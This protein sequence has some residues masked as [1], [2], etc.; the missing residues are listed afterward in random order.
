MI[1]QRTWLIWRALHTPP[2]KLGK[3]LQAMRYTDD[4][5]APRFEVQRRH[6]AGVGLAIGIGLLLIGW[7]GSVDWLA[8]A[9]SGGL[10]VLIGVILL[11]VLASGTLHG[12]RWAFQIATV[13]YHDIHAGRYEL[14]SLSPLGVLGALWMMTHQPN[15]INRVVAFFETVGLALFLAMTLVGLVFIVTL[16]QGPPTVFLSQPILGNVLAIGLVILFF[17]LDYVQAV[18]IGHLSGMY[19]AAV[20]SSLTM[21]Q[22][23]AMVTVIAIQVATYLMA[24]LVAFLGAILATFLF[25]RTGDATLLL[26]SLAFGGTAY[27]FREVAIRVLW[28]TILTHFAVTNV[29]FADF[30]K[31][32]T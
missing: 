30:Q 10:I 13:V 15:R 14:M 6:I 24:G 25:E 16:V 21:A 8:I 31:A 27:A 4:T 26:I 19:L 7:I 22:G 3:Q 28:R 29:E 9:V 12:V 1:A 17:Y 20:A 32:V 23:L 11:L 2:P 18:V 5:P